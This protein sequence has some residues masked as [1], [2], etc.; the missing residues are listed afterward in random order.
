MAYTIN[1]RRR[2]YIFLLFILLL[3]SFASYSTN[4]WLQW[5]VITSMFAILIV[6]D[7]LFL[8]DD[9]FVFDPNY[10][11]WQAATGTGEGL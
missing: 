7:L 6:T 10:R 4:L 8:G 2:L 11:S 5:T 3:V 9:T 1:Y